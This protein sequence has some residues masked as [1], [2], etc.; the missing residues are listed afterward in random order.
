MATSRQPRYHAPWVAAVANG[1]AVWANRVLSGSGPSRTR[2][3]ISADLT[4]SRAG[5]PIARP[6]RR[7]A[8]TSS[9]STSR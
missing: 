3:W 8:S 1:R 6:G 7:S 2:A 5:A 4:G 9:R